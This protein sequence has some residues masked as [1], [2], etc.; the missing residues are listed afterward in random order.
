LPY[1]VDRIT[2]PSWPSWSKCDFACLGLRPHLMLKLVK[3]SQPQSQRPHSFTDLF[4]TVVAEN[5]DAFPWMATESGQTDRGDFGTTGHADLGDEEG[6]DFDR[7][8]LPLPAHLDVD[9]QELFLRPD[10]RVIRGCDEGRMDGNDD[11]D[12][13]PG[14]DLDF[15]LVDQPKTVNDGSIQYSRNS[16]FVDVKLVK[17]HLWD[18]ICD[19]ITRTKASS[20]VEGTSATSFQELVHRTVKRMPKSEC[21]NLS[22]QVC[23]IC[24]LH[25]CNEEGL[26]LKTDALVPLGDFTVLGPAS[27]PI[28]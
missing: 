8:G 17:K 28:A 18:C 16:K 3:K 19:D 21:E 20:G 5:P 6:D 12:G 10:D 24:A 14:L 25:L 22:V 1:M 2:M 23:F 13:P 9:P 27:T 15:D 7:S 11:F 26:E 4:L